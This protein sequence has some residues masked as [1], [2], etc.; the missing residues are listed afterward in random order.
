MNFLILGLFSLILFQIVGCKALNDVSGF[1]EEFGPF[2]SPG[3][4]TVP[5][6]IS[7]SHPLD[8]HP[9]K[10]SVFP[11]PDMMALDTTNQKSTI[12]L[13][14]GETFLEGAATSTLSG[15]AAQKTAFEFDM[16]I[17]PEG[18]VAAGVFIVNPPSDASFAVVVQAL[19]GNNYHYEIRRNNSPIYNQNSP[20]YY[21]RVGFLHENGKIRIWL[22]GTEIDL[23]LLNDSFVADELYALMAVESSAGIPAEFDGM[24]A[25]FEYISDISDMQTPFPADA[26]DS[27]GN[28]R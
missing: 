27:C 8:F 16:K 12:T 11:I 3:N 26:V 14:T 2:V 9:S 6:P 19:A 23:T 21:S 13:Q 15:V 17:L 24:T 18:P 5:E 7:C 25:T 4:N 22:G 20:V 28:T 10:Y 1:E